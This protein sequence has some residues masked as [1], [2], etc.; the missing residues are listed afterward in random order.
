MF[1]QFKSQIENTDRKIEE[2]AQEEEFLRREF[3]LQLSRIEA[4][5]AEV[6]REQDRENRIREAM[7]RA[8]D[9]IDIVR[10]DLAFPTTQNVPSQDST[11][12]QNLPKDSEGS[13]AVQSESTPSVTEVVQDSS[14]T[15]TTTAQVVQT[16]T[17]SLAVLDESFYT[18]ASS[19][20][21]RNSTAAVQS[22]VSNAAIMPP[23]AAT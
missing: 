20:A 9:F 10:N 1:D 22:A 19:P 18:P 2:L 4:R 17:L 13:Q 5:R 7:H 11:S 15:T 8:E 6:L 14:S 21:R 23:P 12:S 3:A 16:A